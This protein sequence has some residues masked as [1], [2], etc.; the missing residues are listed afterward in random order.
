LCHFSSQDQAA[1]SEIYI[2][3]NGQKSKVFDD[4]TLD[5]QTEL[6]QSMF[7]V[8]IELNLVENIVQNSVN[9]AKPLLV[10]YNGGAKAADGCKYPVFHSLGAFH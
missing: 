5:Y 8:G 10:H 3:E 1:L 6:F 2:Q 9:S 4:V 7:D